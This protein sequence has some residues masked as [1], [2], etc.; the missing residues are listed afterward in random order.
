MTNN[1]MSNETT[2]LCIGHWEFIGHSGLVI[3]HLALSLVVPLSSA[4]K[5][6]IA[7]TI[8]L[9]IHVT[10]LRTR[11]QGKFQ[12]CSLLGTEFPEHVI[13]LRHASGRRIDSDPQP[14]IFVRAQRP[15][16]VLQAVV[17]AGAAAAR[18]GAVFPHGRA[19]SSSTIITSAGAS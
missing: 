11:G 1:P 14:R 7:S 19:R 8:P 12:F 4:L 16:D 2:N 10:L 6:F 13:F 18:A 15:L 3:G 9:S 5:R 17:P